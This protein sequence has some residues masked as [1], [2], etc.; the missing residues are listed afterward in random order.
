MLVIDISINRKKFIDEIHIQR[1]GGTPP[2]NC[3]YQ[4]KKPEGYK[5]KIFIHKY[6]DG[7]FPLVLKVLRYLK[8]Q[9][10]KTD[11]NDMATMWLRM[12]KGE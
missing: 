11:N 5:D 6:S 3:K 12:M 9:G 7:C 10:Y 2:G 1:V 8:K 4:I